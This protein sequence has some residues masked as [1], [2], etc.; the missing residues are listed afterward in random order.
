MYA[1]TGDLAGPSLPMWFLL[2][3]T[4]IFAIL[5]LYWILRTRGRAARFLMFACWLRYTLSSLHEFTYNEAVPGL[6][7]VA[8][9]SLAI[10]GT[11]VLVLEKR[12]FISRQFFPV[13]LI[14]GL[15]LVSSIL[16]HSIMAAIEP[17]VRFAI[18]VLIGVALW[19]ALETGG[20]TIL[21]RLLLIFIQPLTYQI[22]SI[23]LGVPKS[24]EL[25]GSLS[26]IGGYFHEEL[27]SLIAATAFLVVM[28]APKLGKFSRFTIALT[29]LAA[30]YLANYRTTM[31]GILP[32]ALVAMY[33]MVPRAI[34]PSQ[35][36][37]ARLVVV[38][39]GITL[40]GAAL[41]IEQD[42][43]SDLGA[44]SHLSSL[45]KAPETFTSAEKRELSS[46]PFI[47]STYLYAYAD[48]ASPLQKVIGFGPD[49]WEGKMPN[50]AHN[51][52]ISFLYELGMAGAVAIILLWVAMFRLALRADKR[53]RP[54][55]IS[56]HAS[57]LVLNLATMAHWQVEG[58]IFYGL[59]SGYTIAKARH[60]RMTKAIAKQFA[61]RQRAV[62]YEAPPTLSPA[63]AQ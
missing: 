24:G 13:Y 10:V 52:V 59:L 40:M 28:F 60:G 53:S 17:I 6:K 35:R 26:Y 55:L 8:L 56:A 33:T 37:F 31:L 11:G 19:Q 16:N 57:F 20:A 3:A 47:W 32:M 38:L 58:N 48:D 18:F 23:A 21:R 22:A 42:R 46:R 63:L 54:L 1:S 12:R 5:T 44:M 9:G 43:F 2:P 49:A 45:I 51:T 14:C 39:G 4:G 36:A 7:W 61:E 34:E 25:D 15:M 27:F 62:R 29:S 41:T 30:I 50:Y